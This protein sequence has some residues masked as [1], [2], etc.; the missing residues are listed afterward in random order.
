MRIYVESD[1][2]LETIE[3]VFQVIRHRLNNYE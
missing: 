3:V 2:L 1:S